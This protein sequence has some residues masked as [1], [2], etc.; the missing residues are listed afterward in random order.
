MKKSVYILLLAM[1]CH[2]NSIAQNVGDELNLM[3]WP[4]KVAL[5]EGRLLLTKDFSLSI[6]GEFDTRIYEYSNRFLRRLDGRT[7]LFF[8]QGMISKNTNFSKNAILKI[9]IER[10]GKI[11]LHEDESYELKVSESEIILKAIT[12]LGAMHGLETLLQ[13]QS[14]TASNFYFPVVVVE[15]APRF[16]WRGL[17][18]D[19]SRH[20]QPVEVIKRNLDA[21][22]AVK[23]NLFHWH[24]S[25]D[26]GFRVEILKHPKLTSLGSD[27]N[28]YTQ[29]QIK[30]VVA[31]ASDRGIQVVPEIDVPG[32]ASALL[33]AYPELSS[34]DR[35][36]SIERNAGIFDPT[37]DPTNKKTYKLLADIFAELATLFPSPYVHIGGD[38]NEGKDWDE[39]EDIQEFMLK[40]DLK[41]N[42]D[43]QTY[44][45]IK[46]Q[47]ILAKSDKVMIGWE[48]ILTPIIPTSAI[49]HSWRGVNEGVPAKQSL[50]DAV[51]NKNQAIL[52]NGYYIDLMYS[53]EDHYAVDPMPEVALTEEEK[54]RILGGEATMWSELVTPNSIDSRIWP[55]TAAIS[56]RFWSPKNIVDME[57][58]HRRLG[59]ISYQLEELGLKHISNRDVVL[60][61]IT[62]NQSIYSLKVLSNICEPLKGYTRNKDGVE[63]QM[64]SPFTLFADACV[65]DAAD[66]RKFKRAV[67]NYV[68]DNSNTE[69]LSKILHVWIVQNEAFLS[70][71]KNPKLN[72]IAPLYQ[73]LTT[74]SKVLLAAI[75]TNTFNVQDK[76][77]LRA[78]LVRMQEANEVDVEFA[79]VEDLVVLAEF[80]SQMKEI[81]PIEN[82]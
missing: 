11:Q 50:V 57:S 7:G 25:D 48:E 37:L 78:A 24:L 12:D 46:L 20:F 43:L 79:I 21:M 81:Q 19:V 6:T 72:S 10:P 4:Q 8:N 49:I 26:Q 64:Y 67:A 77:V 82:K 80:V 23:M 52:S 65:A 58:M 17:M 61:N 69:E 34:I 71:N 29:A 54:N 31:Y 32:H 56:E 68:S 42:H 55:R 70:L 9:N 39:N 66:K 27:G 51:K 13:L 62:N 22:A 35:E 1:C 74:V 2:F 45:N 40:N 3:P 44:F 41:S 30:E 63:Y 59:I 47:K 15:D 73:N 76:D 16:P 60:R 53:V 28:Y 33:T 36:N 38:E 75:T 18:I 5:G 14:T